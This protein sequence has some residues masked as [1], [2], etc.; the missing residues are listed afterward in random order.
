MEFAN[1]EGVS[2]SVIFAGDVGNISVPLQIC[3][4]YTHIVLVDAMPLAILEAMMARKPIIATSVGGIPEAITNDLTGLLVE[5]DVDDIA[6]KI[7][8]LLENR[9]IAGKLGENA[10]NVADRRFS[11]PRLSSKMRSLYFE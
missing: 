10:K 2:N 6:S 7:Q 9:D 1:K 8:Y 11:I 5:P 4:L 3:D